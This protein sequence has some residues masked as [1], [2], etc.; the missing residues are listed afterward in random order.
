MI[1]NLFEQNFKQLFD[2]VSELELLS[3]SSEHQV[4]QM[5]ATL[6]ESKS[7]K[8]RLMTKL[9]EAERKLAEYEERLEQQ[10]KVQ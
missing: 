6:R 5:Q 1:N 9:E 8:Y 10:G 3:K 2:E 7:E 4:M